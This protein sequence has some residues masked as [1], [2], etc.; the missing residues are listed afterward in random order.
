MSS[1]A[2]PRLASVARRSLLASTLAAA[3]GAH[4]AEA[5]PF[6]EGKTVDCPSGSICTLKL[7]GTPNTVRLNLQ[8]VSCKLLAT[9]PVASWVL[10]LFD[11]SNALFIPTHAQ[12]VELRSFVGTAPVTFLTGGRKIEVQALTTTPTATQ[13]S[14]TLTGVTAPRS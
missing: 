9:E 10:Q 14:C 5:A 4:A 8:H 11:G 3:L 6:Q 1:I 12:D 13:L 2:R 7:G